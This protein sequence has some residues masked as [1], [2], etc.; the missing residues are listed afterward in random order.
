MQ[1]RLLLSD[2]QVPSSEE[3][4]LIPIQ[5]Y[6]LKHT[7]GLRSVILSRIRSVLDFGKLPS[8]DEGSPLV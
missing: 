7:T 3:V 6:A 4:T 5:A 2:F 8:L 1:P